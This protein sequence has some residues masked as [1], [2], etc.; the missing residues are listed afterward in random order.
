MYAKGRC[1]CR[2]YHGLK[3]DGVMLRGQALQWGLRLQNP[4]CAP[5]QTPKA[6]ASLKHLLGGAQPKYERNNGS[7]DPNASPQFSLAALKSQASHDGVRHRTTLGFGI[8]WA[9][10]SDHLSPQEVLAD[11]CNRWNRGLQHFVLEVWR[12][13]VGGDDF[14]RALAEVVHGVHLRLSC[15]RPL[16][17][18]SYAAAA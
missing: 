8:C 6:Q 1:L 11:N 16:P 12:A 10:V 7:N 14:L 9:W 5:T 15:I 4:N 18:A 3:T 13:I 2:N 17:R